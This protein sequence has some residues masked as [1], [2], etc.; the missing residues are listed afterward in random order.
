M[1]VTLVLAGSVLAQADGRDLARWENG[2]S[3]DPSFFPI[4]VWL[5]DPKNA[6]RFQEA[7]I[8]LY[9][10]LWKG[11]TEAQLA[12]LRE[13]GMRVICSQNAV[14]LAHKDDKTIAAWMHNDEP[15]NAQTITD[16]KTG[17]RRYGGPVPPEKVVADYE[18]LRAADPTR[19]VLLNLG[20]GVAN[21]AW[22]GR[23]SGAKPEDYLTYVQGADIVS[24][25]VY[26]VAGINRDDGGDLL[27]YVAKGVDRLRGW[28]E[29]RKIIWNCIEASRV[30]NLKAKVTPHQLRAEVWMSLVHGSTGLIYFVHQFQPTFKEASLL[31]DPELLPAVTAVNRQVRELA[32][33]LNAPTIAEGVSVVSTNEDV[34]I[35]VMVKRH[36]GATYV[37][38][39]AMRNGPTRGRFTLPGRKGPAQVDV[40]GE[41]RSLVAHEGRFEDAFQPFDV[42][43]FK[44]AD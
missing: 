36:A 3:A 41:G 40:L 22:K 26:P 15:D 18:R 25:D 16:P 17:Q 8:N 21:D 19:P 2:P 7:G 32:P 5:Q 38:A 43:L 34:P 27:W 28:S 23:G 13:A 10:G 14:G 31:D 35:D 42:H 37:F 30:S 12:A 39:V 20:Q 24:Y 1:F 4:A 44:I 6:R 33:V 29:G 11:P 9:V